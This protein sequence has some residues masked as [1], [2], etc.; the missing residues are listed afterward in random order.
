MKTDHFKVMTLMGTSKTLMHSVLAILDTGAG[1]NMVRES[2]L[3]KDWRRFLVKTD[4]PYP[5]IRDANN[6]QLKVEGVVVLFVDV[7]GV[8]FRVR[9]LVCKNLAVKA[10]LG[11]AFIR[12]YVQGIFPQEDKV[13]LRDGGSV[14]ILANQKS[15]C[16]AV[17]S[18]EPSAERPRRKKIRPGKRRDIRLSQTV[19]VPPLSEAIVR[20]TTPTKG[21][22]LVEPIPNLMR[23]HKMTIPY[24]V[25]DPI[26]G[27]EFAMTLANFGRRATRLP[28]GTVIGRTFGR[29]RFLLSPD[30]ALAKR[31][32]AR[33]PSSREMQEEPQPGRRD[34]R[35]RSPSDNRPT[36]PEDPDWIQD[37]GLDHLDP[38]TKSKMLG[39]LR[40]YSEICDGRLG[41]LKGV[42]HRIEL[43][44]GSTPIFQQ[45]YRAGPEARKAEAAEVQRMLEAEVIV[46][47]I[48]EWASPVILVPKPDQSLRFCVDY[49]RLNSVTKRDSYPMPRMDECIDSLGNA[50]IFS[51]LDCNSGYW[52]LPIAEGDQEKTTFTCHA[53]SYKFLRMP[54][55]LRN[56]PATFQRAMDIIL[57]GV[58]WK[59]C[60]VYLDDIIVFSKNREDHL[61][62]LEEVFR[63]LRDA[64][65]TLRLKK[66]EFFKDEVKYLGHVI[67]PGRLGMLQKNVES[68]V[69]AMPPKTK[70]QMRSFLGMCNVYRRF[71]KGYAKIAHPLNRRTS[72]DSPETWDDL[73]E[74]EMTAFQTLKRALVTAPILA[75]PRE[76]Y[77]Y[78]LDTDAS[79]Y[80]I[81]CCLLQE[82][83]DGH[84]LPVGYWSRSLTPAERNYS[85]TE[86]ECLAVV[87]ATLHLRPYL[88][89]T[90]FTI[91]TDHEAL[92]WL[93]N[94]RDPRG[95]LARWG[96]RIQEFDFEIQYRPGSSHALADGPSRLATTGLDESHLNDEIP[97]LPRFSRHVLRPQTA[98]ERS[99][100]PS[101]SREI[102]TAM[103][104]RNDELRLPISVDEMLV[105]QSRD[106]YCQWARRQ[107][108]LSTSSPFAIDQHGVLIRRSP[109]DGTLQ[110][111]VPES[112]RRRL[113]DIAHNPPI[114]AHPGRSRMYQT[115]RRDF[116][117][118]SMTVDIHFVVE[119]CESCARNRIK[120][121]R[122]V[123]PMKLFPADKPLD[124]VA[125]DILGPLPKTKH[126]KRFILVVTDRFSKLTKTE[127]LR[128]ITSLS[129]AKAFCRIWVFN[130]GTPSIL[131]TDNGTQ[132]TAR[133]FMNVCRILGIKKVFTTAYHPQANGQAERFNRTILAGLRN[134]VSESQRDWDEW[135]EPLTYAYNMQVHRSTG[136][137]PFDLVLTRHPPSLLMEEDLREHLPQASPSTSSRRIASAK[138]EFL[139]R[140]AT[141]MAKARANLKRTQLRYKRNFDSRV[142]EKLRNLKPGSYVYREIAEHPAGVNPKLVSQVD[143]PFEVLSNDWPTIVIDD[144]GSPV[145]VNANRLVRAPTPRRR[146][147]P[148]QR[149]NDTAGVAPRLPRDEPGGSPLEEGEEIPH[150]PFHAQTETPG[151]GDCDGA[152]DGA[153]RSSARRAARQ[154]IIDADPLSLDRDHIGPYETDADQSSRDWYPLD[155]DEAAAQLGM[156]QSLEWE[157]REYATP[158]SRRDLYPGTPGTHESSAQGSEARMS[159][160]DEA[161]MQLGLPPSQEWD[162]LSPEWDEAQ[163]SRSDP[164]PLTDQRMR[165][166]K[167]IPF[168]MGLADIGAAEA[169]EWSRSD[170]HPNRDRGLAS[171]DQ[172]DHPSARED[173]RSIRRSTRDQREYEIERLLDAGAAEDGSIL[174]RVRW[175]GYGPQDDTWEPEQNLPREMVRAARQRHGLTS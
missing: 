61:R 168:Q 145:R 116:Y 81:G 35:G 137:T 119:N 88:E 94:L 95:R 86:K 134:Y 101:P 114:S 132:F 75:L 11:C 126:G 122:N 51:T 55:G 131:L 140:F 161:A 50:N 100:A 84:L 124:F 21:I 109:L 135:L 49:R 32:D 121:Q 112:L 108:D 96:L 150:S 173:G 14:A 169:R 20:V 158:R 162:M 3:P 65:A 142:R 34:A 31:D 25:I 123:Y 72:K 138:K 136:T 102:T 82:Q 58:R 47:S 118:P 1:P 170:T 57:S 27:C 29:P 53:G 15:I 48:S 93:L 23:R 17:S 59:C 106:E 125:A 45:P 36:Y 120:D 43:V 28:R 156:P 83:P 2:F 149:D 171:D 37:V 67:R 87:W 98:D 71:I 154:G 163:G 39:L 113:L 143:G 19:T 146:G 6:R 107:M 174:F 152:P 8:S 167:R 91:R 46:P 66:C 60:I 62:H 110:V 42:L 22:H 5:V 97:C 78:T 115:L 12:R 69:K 18:A 127:S 155:E 148:S 175:K 105:E 41:T 68:I 79:A 74:D 104:V 54:F 30:D 130:Y 33:S 159:F 26:G 165:A 92:R 7:G 40:K 52:Q 64:G 89:R 139:A 38:K 16:A 128:T 76:G 157:S 85:S 77:P 117:W 70:T 166:D 56:A 111:V 80:Q 133:F 10:I 141:L 63:L 153:P 160:E 4:S 151:D 24:G 9:F 147:D 164:D 90:R 172:Y 44:P 144:H 129:V 99:E 13:I 103:V 73:S